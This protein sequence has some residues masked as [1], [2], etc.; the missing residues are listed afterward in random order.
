MA[1]I[2]IRRGL[3]EPDTSGNFV[4]HK[5]QRP[6]KLEPGRPFKVVSEYQPAGDQPTAIADL[7]ASA[8][9]GERTQVLLG[10]TGSGKTFTMAKVIE[11]LQRPALILAPNK[12]LAAQLYGEMKSFF[13]ENAVEYFVSYYDYYQPEAYV[14]RS[15]TYIEKES[16][17]NEAI[18][19]MRHS[20]TRALLER[21]DV[22]I[23]ASV[24]CLYGIGSVETYSAMVFDLKKGE[25]VD[26]GEIVRKLV[27]LQY[28]RNDHAFQRGTFRV[29]GDNLEIFPSHYEDTAW[30][31]TFFG[32]EIEEIAEFDPLTGKADTR[33]SQVRVYANSHHVTPGP[34][35]M[36]AREAIKFELAERLKELH[37]EGKLLE[38]QRLEQRTHFDLEMMAATGSCAGIENYSRFLTGRLPG[39][40]PPTL[41]EYLPDNALLFVDESHQ[42][43]PQIGAMARGDHRRKMTL[44]EYGFRLPSCID[45]RP[46]RFNEWEA[47][48]PQTFAVS[49]TPG[50]W[51]ME[52]AGGVFA[53]Q[54]IRPTG[55]I[56]PPVLIRPVEDQVQD[57]INEC[58]LTAQN[59]YRTLVTTL[60][61]RM[62]ED[63]TEFM[64]EA[65]LRVRYMHSDVETLE[66]IELIRDLRLGVYD[67]LV[68]INLLREGLD[69]PECGL[70]C[71][72][73]ADKEGFLRSETSL[74]QTIGRAA[75][76]V[77]GRVILYADRMTGSM[78]RAIAETDRRREK[79]NAYNELH[80]ITPATIKRQIADIIADTASRDGVLVDLDDDSTNNLVGH[81]LRS[82]IEDLEKRMRNAAADLEFEEAGRLRDE[83]RR[84]ESTELGLP[85]GDRKAPVVGR[86]NEGKPGTR[87]TRY[88]KS[89]KKW[90]K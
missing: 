85:E 74:I 89:Q 53:E 42:T 7:V 66:R 81:N 72:L 64:H 17:V 76:N 3:E 57:C 67:V 88:G 39:E 56:D 8:R 11:E 43:V 63:L 83:I 2:I 4:P 48:R 28:K 14:P 68:G 79:Q 35:L 12:I 87:K 37:A 45:N 29:R 90:G 9:E 82:H 18:D 24:S 46:L 73:D 16:S 54:V 62:A 78:E 10:V 25:S 58:R 21:D 22:I 77:D 30:R 34:T 33:L 71:I 6:A 47:M 50:N 51:E 26:Q 84:L 40:P 41:F 32:D 60:T 19:R 80:G 31:V 20:A 86:S 44:A 23:V 5:P 38:A 61:K 70:V 27:A 15:D 59:G 49:A 1:E 65:G 52:Q 75:R 13:P 36:Q 55:L 69:I